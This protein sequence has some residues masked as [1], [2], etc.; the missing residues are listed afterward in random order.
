MK[1]KRLSLSLCRLTEPPCV[2][3][4]ARCSLSK[5]LSKIHFEPNSLFMRLI[6]RKRQSYNTQK[7]IKNSACQQGRIKLVH[8]NNALRLSPR[9]AVVQ[10]VQLVRNKPLVV[11]DSN[12][13]HKALQSYNEMR[14]ATHAKPSRDTKS[15]LWAVVRIQLCDVQRPESAC[16]TAR[17]RQPAHHHTLRPGTKNLGEER[18]FHHIGNR[19]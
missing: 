12:Q 16:E 5:L 14:M 9:T 17:S 8:H 11:Q 4:G 2:H 13:N 18:K 10:S 7:K 15:N 19:V 3:N 6:Q 1:S